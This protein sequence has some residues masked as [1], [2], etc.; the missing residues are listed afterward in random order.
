MAETRMLPVKLTKHE[1]E[2]RADA[3]VN[4]LKE[5]GD[6][7][8]RKKAQASASKVAIEQATDKIDELARIVRNGEEDRPVDVRTEY[9][10]AERMARFVRVDTGAEIGSRPMTVA[11]I[12]E[13]EQKK[14]PFGEPR[15]APADEEITTAPRRKSL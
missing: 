3:L 9:S 2:Q 5:R 4:L 11:E 8:E 6:L 14:L 13:Q 7:E 12:A 10:L 15:E 1:K